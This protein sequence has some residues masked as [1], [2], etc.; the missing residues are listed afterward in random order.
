[1]KAVLVLLITWAVC[2]PAE[3]GGHSAGSRVEGPS[4]MGQNSWFHCTNQHSIGLARRGLEG[5]CGSVLGSPKYDFS[6]RVCRPIALFHPR[7]QRSRGILQC[8]GRNS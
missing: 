5:W 6:P 7:P 3:S 4:G 8:F 1:V 2:V